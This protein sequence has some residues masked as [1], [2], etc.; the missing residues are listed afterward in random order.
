MVV[1]TARVQ[2]RKADLRPQRLMVEGRNWIEWWKW[3]RLKA[4]VT[5]VTG[6]DV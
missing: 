4:A 2:P 5:Q 1:T 3:S 6:G